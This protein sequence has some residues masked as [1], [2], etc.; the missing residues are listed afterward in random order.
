MNN[1]VL[2][3]KI[4]SGGMGVVHKAHHQGLH[5][6]VAVKFLHAH[7]A[8]DAEAVE[9]FLREARLIARMDHPNIV[10]VT[11]TGRWDD[12]RPYL[13][14]ELLGGESLAERL[15]RGPLNEAEAVEVACQ[16]LEA[17]SVAHR[18]GIVHRDIKP[19]NVRLCPGGVVKLLDFGIARASAGTALS[20]TGSMI[21]TPAYMSPE[22]A[23]GKTAGP[24]SDLYSVGILLYEMLT[25]DVPF[26]ADTPLVVLR[27]HTDRPVPKLPDHV[28]KRTRRAVERALEKKSDR[29]PADA[30]TMIRELREGVGATPVP[31]S[32]GA[33]TP[34]PAASATPLP[35]AAAPSKRSP[36]GALVALIVVGLGVL[37]WF[38]PMMRTLVGLP[39]L[40]AMQAT[41]EVVEEEVPFETEK[42]HDDSLKPG[43]S[44]IERAG[45]PGTD[46][47][48]Y[49]V[50][51]G[52]RREISR[53]TLIAPVQEIVVSSTMDKQ[54]P[55]C[56]TWNLSDARYCQN[57]G[58]VQAW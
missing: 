14:M 10:R 41:T 45:M 3:E 50:R 35:A 47:V 56:K 52:Q 34:Q 2:G 26:K 13:V 46:R 9:R 33:K 4:G 30:A 27:M 22:Q 15:A 11:D 19:G 20:G 28:S 29:R 8:D 39:P 31:S 12:G 43:A 7:L 36:V 17:L 49:E 32:A 42:R 38:N 24:S 55:L 57:A 1:Y 18:E 37:C 53:E 23:E 44:R 21:G 25:G 16:V 58:C 51:E 6:D 54:C 5:R 48:T 40:A